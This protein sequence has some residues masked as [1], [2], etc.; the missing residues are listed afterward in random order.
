MVSPYPLTAHHRP[1]MAVCV[2]ALLAA[3]DAGAL[4]LRPAWGQTPFLRFEHLDQRDGLSM[5]AVETVLQDH[6]GFVWLGTQDGLHRFDGEQIEVFSPSP[7]DPDSLASGFIECLA[8]DTSGRLW[9]GTNHSGLDSYDPATDSYRHFRHDPDDPTSLAS[10]EIK[11]LLV[12]G[13]GHLLVGTSAGLDRLDL[14]TGRILPIAPAAATGESE[15][16]GSTGAVSTDGSPAEGSGASGPISIRALHRDAAGRIW[17]GSLQGLLRVDPVAGTWSP[18]SLAGNPQEAR[19]EVRS[20]ADH[21]DGSLW[22]VTPEALVR[23]RP[24]EGEPGKSGTEGGISEVFSH[25]PEDRRS[26][27]DQELRKMLVDDRGRVWV[28]A[29]DG[30]YLLQ[31]PAAGGRPYF[32]HWTKRATE[33]DGLADSNLLSLYQDRGGI[34]WIGTVSGGVDRVDPR[35]LAFGHMLG[36]PDDAKGSTGR[37]IYAF[38]EDPEGDIWIGTSSQGVFRWDRGAGAFHRLPTQAPSARGPHGEQIISLLVDSRRRLWIGTYRAGL[39]VLDLTTDRLETLPI[40]PSNAS[41][42]ASESILSLF[43]DSAGDLWAGSLRSGLARFPRGDGPPERFRAAVRGGELVDDRVTS[44]EEDADNRLWAGTLSG[45]SV[46]DRGRGTFAHLDPARNAVSGLRSD[47]VLSL[48]RDSLGRL[49]VGTQE[50]GIALLEHF[51]G[52]PETA[53]FRTWTSSDGLANNTVYGILAGDRGRIWAS[54][55]Q[56][57]SRLDP[58]SGE[59]V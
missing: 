13:D 12:L 9:I 36:N 42:Q 22:W 30:L 32:H 16:A 20:I 8:E 37:R 15:A 7:G 11:A 45:L 54:T 44:M 47:Y 39:R 26:L 10:D 1:R 34:L 51:D 46:F 57:L 28:A 24:G 35:S 33:P 59:I 56:G 53:V 38:A 14:A 23:H 48:H 50:G 3:L 25:D 31:R 49:W 52:R 5:D 4:G 55:N 27:G 43:E 58:E 17:A 29:L 21:P 18:A 40:D 6:H 19:K 2:V 41:A